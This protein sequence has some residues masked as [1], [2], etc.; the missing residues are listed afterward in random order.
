M[1]SIA[2]TSV[3]LNKYQN[4]NI[5]YLL[6]TCRKWPYSS[7]F[8]TNEIA[9]SHCFFFVTTLMGGCAVECRQA[10]YLTIHKEEHTF[11]AQNHNYHLHMQLCK[12]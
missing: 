5:C 7:Y 12:L 8:E 3:V 9:A 4:F 2:V 6:Q 11:Y 10:I 1:Q